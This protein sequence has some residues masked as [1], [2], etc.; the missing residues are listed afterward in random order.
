M[1]AVVEEAY[2]AMDGL[3]NNCDAAPV[4]VLEAM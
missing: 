1:D 3:W 4:V 2:W